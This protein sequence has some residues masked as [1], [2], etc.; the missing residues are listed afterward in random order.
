MISAVEKSVT[1]SHR[2]GDRVCLFFELKLF[3]NIFGG[4]YMELTKE[5]AN[6]YLS[7]WENCKINPDYESDL[8]RYIDKIKENQ[9]V[10]KTISNK[11]G[12][13][14]YVIA[15]MH[16]DPLIAR[17]TRVPAGRPAHGAP[18]FSWEDSAI[19][20]L[21]YDGALGVKFW[22]LPTLFWFLEGFNGWGYRVGK[23]RD[24]TP[25][26]RSA[27]IYSGTK[28]YEKGKY[29][30]DGRFD[31]D[32]I[33]VQ[34]GC[35]A[36]LKELESRNLIALSPSGSEKI[37]EN[38]VGSVSAWQH[39]L[40]GC[41]YYPVLTINGNMDASTIEMTKT[42]Q[43]DLSLS[44]SGIVDLATWQAGFNH[45][46]LPSWSN[47]VPPPSKL[48]NPLPGTPPTDSDSTSPLG[49]TTTKLHNFY[50]Q[51]SNYDAVYDNV[52]SWYGTTSN[53]CVAFASSA[54]RLSGYNVPKTVNS[55]GFGI[56]LWTAA[57]SEYL[58]N[59]GWTQSTNA[60][61]LQPGDIVFTDDGGF[62][63]GI[64]MH[65]YVFSKWHDTA[66]E[67]AWVIDNQ[68]FTHRRNIYDGG[69]GFNF[70]PFAYFLRA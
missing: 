41:G 58:L 52:M 45:R 3:R 37:A 32:A 6:E 35:M 18:P 5:L 50:A 51:A 34:V 1:F 49:G 22:N 17:T 70:T 27:Y 46:K 31:P 62:G 30:A 65:V 10:Y 7:L 54:L 68:D 13:P 20:A 61:A 40:N 39:I 21:E 60:N 56:S 69:G 44:V 47:L 12:I 23:G 53:A 67:V 38:A 9:T 19:D 59:Q 26:F 14:W 43:T 29:T 42:F 55:Q 4:L 8:N 64:P 33:S 24:T 57:F 66:K 15:V 25:P 28:F 63:D 48:K 11:T 36:Q 16:G 2:Q